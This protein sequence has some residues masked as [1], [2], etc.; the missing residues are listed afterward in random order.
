MHVRRREKLPSPFFQPT[1]AG[2]G[3][4]LRAVAIATGIEGDDA[5]SAARALIEMTAEHG[6]T[7]PHDSQ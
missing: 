3:L 4:T 5:M 1:I 6:G 2:T 7:T